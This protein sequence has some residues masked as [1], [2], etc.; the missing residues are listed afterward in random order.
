MVAWLGPVRQEASQQLLGLVCLEVSQ[1]MVGL[2]IL[3][4]LLF[5]LS[6]YLFYLSFLFCLA[7]RLR[8]ALAPMV[9]W[10]PLL[11]LVAV[12]PLQPP[13]CCPY[14]LSCLSSPSCPFPFCP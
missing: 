1:Q 4:Y 2:G 6:P 13:H 3:E 8:L 5:C 9:A 12:L 7:Y 10:P 14:S 11:V